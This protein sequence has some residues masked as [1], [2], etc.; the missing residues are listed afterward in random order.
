[1]WY[2]L[3][4]RT[5]LQSI[6]WLALLPQDKWFMKMLS[7]KCFKQLQEFMQW[8][9]FKFVSNYMQKVPNQLLLPGLPNKKSSRSS[10]WEDLRFIDIEVSRKILIVHTFFQSLKWI[11]YIWEFRLE[12][13]QNNT[14]LSQCLFVLLKHN[15]I[16]RSS[17]LKV[18]IALNLYLKWK[19]FCSW[20]EVSKLAWNF[21]TCHRACIHIVFIEFVVLEVE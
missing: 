9:R 5:I 1:M 15:W 10:L 19:R 4:Y 13:Y 16:M 14:T 7:C 11:M 17:R 2:P 21:K 12:I 20:Q 18:L 8:Y 3:K 6:Q